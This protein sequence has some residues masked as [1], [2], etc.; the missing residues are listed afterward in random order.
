MKKVNF[1]GLFELSL[2]M[3]IQALGPL[4]HTGTIILAT[5]AGTQSTALAATT[6]PFPGDFAILLRDSFRACK[7]FC[8]ISCF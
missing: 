4:R 6:R 3:H 5:A 7:G 2:K 1:T 8:W